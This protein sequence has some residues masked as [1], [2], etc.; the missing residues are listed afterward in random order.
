[1]CL[2]HKGLLMIGLSFVKNVTT[3]LIPILPGTFWAQ[4]LAVFRILRFLLKLNG[5]RCNLM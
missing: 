1:M 5:L 4:K 2:I 3:T